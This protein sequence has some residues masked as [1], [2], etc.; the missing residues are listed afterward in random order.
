MFKTKL[1][2][3]TLVFFLI[4]SILVLGFPFFLTQN[5]FATAAVEPVDTIVSTGIYYIRNQKS[6]LYLDVAGAGTN[7]G[8]TLMQYYYNGSPNQTFKI[9]KVGDYYEIIPIYA[10]NMRLDIRNAS[11]ENEAA[12][13]LYES[14][15][16]NAQRF[17]IESTGNGDNSFKILTGCT[18]YTKCITAKHASLEPIEVFQYGYGNN[19]NEDNDHWYFE[20]VTLNEK[21]MI[22]VNEG[23][24]RY[25]DFKVPDNGFYVAET[26]PINNYS[27]NIVTN[28]TVEGLKDGQIH[29]RSYN[30]V[31]GHTM[32]TFSGEGGQH[33][34][35][36]VRSFSP[37][38]SI[39]YFQ[40]RRQ[41]AI[42]CG[43][44]YGT[45]EINTL[46][47]L[48]VPNNVLSSMYS[49]VTYQDG[50]TNLLTNDLR[51]FPII[52][53]EVLFFSG[54]GNGNSVSLPNGSNLYASSLPQMNNVRVAVWSSCKSAEINNGT[55]MV[56]ES[57][58]Q[59][60]LSSLGFTYTVGV[61]SAKTF[62]DELFVQLSQG[63]TLTGAAVMAANKIIWPWDTV[64][65]YVIAGDPSTRINEASFIKSDVGYETT[66]LNLNEYNLTREE[67]A[68]FELAQGK[69]R[70]F[71]TINGCLTNQVF[72]CND[73]DNIYNT[74][75]TKDDSSSTI[76]PVLHESQLELAKNEELLE[77]HQVYIFTE[78]VYTPVLLEYINCFCEYGVYQ[79]VVCKNLYNGELIDYATI[80]SI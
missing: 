24:I 28:V 1:L 77:K 11:T 32:F 62:T 20:D 55:S 71:K 58:N 49:C 25:F 53:S 34:R 23:D 75:V 19:G 79:K 54:H 80:N 52:N 50:N 56:L 44:N 63:S 16:T 61:D 27:D 13:Q 74:N 65:D 78:G 68:S 40:I 4:L 51:D 15:S 12:L 57:V 8:A 14:N 73:E 7:N 64:K 6:G 70:L 41:Q 72:D 69:T 31:G 37:S 3:N 33:L 30:G 21:H 76:L 26:Y 10:P 47:D 38:L 22:W 66:N 48:T 35:F 18:N 36:A 46:P 59:G 67:C 9:I 43:F 45:D 29:T 17:S 5:M 60:A 42:L 39:F 2:T